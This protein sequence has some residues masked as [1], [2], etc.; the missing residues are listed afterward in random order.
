MS[1][2]Q[3]RFWRRIGVGSRIG[4]RTVGRVLWMADVRGVRSGAVLEGRAVIQTA[5][6]RVTLPHDDQLHDAHS[7]LSCLHRHL[8]PSPLPAPVI[9]RLRGAA[10]ATASLAVH[11]R[12]H[13]ERDPAC[14]SYHD[15][16]LYFKGFQALQTHRVAHWLYNSGRHALAFY[17]Q[18]QVSS[19]SLPARFSMYHPLPPHFVHFPVHDN[20]HI[21]SPSHDFQVNQEFQIDIHPGA[22][23]GEG[24]FID[25]GTGIVV[26]ETAVVGNDVSM[27]HRVTLGGSGVKSADRHPK[28]RH[29]GGGGDKALCCLRA[30]FSTVV[31]A[32]WILY[33][34]ICGCVLRAPYSSPQVSGDGL[35]VRLFDLLKYSSWLFEASHVCP[36]MVQS[37]TGLVQCASSLSRMFVR[38]LNRFLV[39]PDE[40][41]PLTQCSNPNRVST[42]LVGCEEQHSSAYVS[43]APDLVACVHSLLPLPLVFLSHACSA[44]PHRKH[45]GTGI[46]ITQLRLTRPLPEDWQRRAD[47]CG[48]LPPRKHQ[49][50]GR[51][52]DWRWIAGGDG[53]T[54]KVR[55]CTSSGHPFLMRIL[56]ET[57][58]HFIIVEYP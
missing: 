50:W 18:S 21:R 48:G 3:E 28:V 4:E 35:S 8:E 6:V 2:A 47:W 49:G 42:P 20:K 19:A 10:A 14:D 46:S 36:S 45:V 29:S 43:P 37:F 38:I 23:F 39:F 24:V 54:G 31:R 40:T 15:C 16:L 51:D 26:G 32:F 25:H 44:V 34:C 56:R 33:M 12:D 11:I 30:R 1:I 5:Y 27:L 22:K 52:T 55:E 53:L 58:L 57:R 13:R 7:S 17:L 9:L 41:S